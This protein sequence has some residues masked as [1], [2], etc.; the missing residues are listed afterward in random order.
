MDKRNWRRLLHRAPETNKYDYGHVLIIG[1]SETMVGA[2]VLAARATL[3][4]G[5]GLVTVASTAEVLRSVDRDVEEIMTFS[6]PSWEDSERAVTAIRT[7]IKERSVSVIILGPGLPVAADKTIRALLL[8]VKLP[9]VL[10]AEVFTA[11]G[12]HIGILEDAASMNERIILTPHP[13]EYARL[14]KSNPQYS[15]VDESTAAEKFAQ[16]YNITLI[17]KQHHT[18]VLG[19]KGEIFTNTTGNPGLATAGSG[20]V[21]SGITAGMLAQKMNAFEAAKMAVYLH[22]LAG[23]IAAESKTEPGMIASD[24]IEAIPQAL[25]LLDN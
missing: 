8:N 12:G 14:V 5:A 1:G 19:N 3:R 9:L 16:D 15:L 18:L 4:S 21:L 13:G 23:D 17:L 7:F 10:D 2:P 22:G 24:I 20:D 6:L 11:L 25:R